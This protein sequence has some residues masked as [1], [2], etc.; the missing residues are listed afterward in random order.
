M[1]LEIHNY[2]SGS[3]LLESEP[4]CWDAI[5]ILDSSLSE[6]QFVDDHAQRS[7]QLRFD[8]ITQSVENKII[9]SSEL[10][11]KALDFGLESEKL[12]VCC[13]AGQSRSS[14]T[15]FSI[16][17]EKL[18]DDAALKLLNPKRHSPNFRVI[19]IANELVE[20]PGLLNLYDQ[21]GFS[22]RDQRLTDYLDE[23]EAEYD[24]LEE[25]GARDRISKK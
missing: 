5:V 9:P 4:N 8:D 21:W 16:A 23:I 18:G 25:L 10:I 20:R 11:E 15:A 22:I 6:S 7:L 12:M 13:R 17:F 24:K 1:R 14:A 19:Q 3:F 2:L